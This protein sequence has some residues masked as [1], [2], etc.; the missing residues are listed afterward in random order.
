MHVLVLGATG[1]IGRHVVGRLLASGHRVTAVVR[2]VA[3]CR[4]R[5]PAA[6]AVF[7]DLNEMIEPE[8]WHELLAG[9]DAVVNCAGILQQRRGQSIA[10]IHRDAPVALFRACAQRGVARVVQISAVSA[11]ADAGT[12]YARTKK[13]ADDALRALDLDWTV[14]RPSL[15]YGAGSFGGTSFLRGIAGLPWVTPLIAD[16]GQAFT[17]VHVDDLAT[18]VLM[19]L[20][21]KLARRSLDPCGPETLTLARIVALTRGWLDLAPA[22]EWPLPLV[23][24]RWVARIGDFV[25]AGPVNS[26]A[27][28]QLEYGN[29]TDPA[30][31]AAAVGFRPRAMAES[32]AAS[33]SH[34]QDRW[35]A[36]LY[37]LRPLLTLV[38]AAIWLGSGIVGLVAPAE[39]VRAIVVGVGLPGASAPG[40]AVAACLLDIVLAVS[41]VATP[42]RQIWISA[43]AQLAAVLGYSVALSVVLPALWLDPFGPLLKN[44]AVVALIGVWAALRDER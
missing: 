16:G 9:I 14:L 38:L 2:D 5:F 4:R 1:F 39:T 33:P 20:D 30:P 28:R 6:R 40:I 36:R 26:T 43:S 41:V 8:R 37:F 23:L 3:S 11:D 25:G 27:L 13:A 34:V 21:G 32:Y 42:R 15:V 29:A 19:A 35:H 17:P 7:A 10:A 44:L 31:F 12:D 18:T 22:R 24:V